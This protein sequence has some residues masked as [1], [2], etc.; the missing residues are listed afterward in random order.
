M[1]HHADETGRK[2]RV[3][4][5][6][7]AVNLARRRLAPRVSIDHRCCCPELQLLD[8]LSQRSKGQVRP[9]RFSKKLTPQIISTSSRQRLKRAFH[10]STMIDA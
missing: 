2:R 3:V 10:R 9:G 1:I 7:D 8:D 4:P 5:R 6:P